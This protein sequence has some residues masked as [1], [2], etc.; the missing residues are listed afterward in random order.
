MAKFKA[1]VSFSGPKISMRCGEVRELSDQALIDGL[2]KAGHIIELV[3]THKK[4]SVSIEKESE[5]P[6]E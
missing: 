6:K 5:E 2:L 1:T 3:E 4:N